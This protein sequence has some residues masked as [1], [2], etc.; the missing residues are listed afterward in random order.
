ML[1][2]NK[3]IETNFPAAN[4]LKLGGAVLAGALVA[5]DIVKGIH[6]AS[7]RRDYTELCSNDLVDADQTVVWL[8]GCSQDGK[9]AYKQLVA[10]TSGVNI[11][12]PRLPERS[13]NGS[14]NGREI[15]KLVLDKLLETGAKKPKIIADSRGALDAILLT[16]M[17]HESGASDQFGGFSEVIFNASPHDGNDIT[18]SR[19]RLL[20]GAIGLQYSSIAEHIKQRIMKGSSHK[21]IGKAPMTK[22]VAEGRSIRQA[23]A[24][25]HIPPVMEKLIY[26]R[27][28]YHDS[29]VYAAQ[30]AEKYRVEAPAGTFQEYIDYSREPGTHIGGR[31]RFDLLLELAGITRPAVQEAQPIESP[32]MLPQAA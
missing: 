13:A 21:S 15:G 6:D 20:N 24:F 29:T 2:Q 22:I 23:P 17:A 9:D 32:F 7:E 30:A 19:N 11:I 31:E 28:Q 3:Y 1:E 26:V 10:K 14:V 8:V 16:Q 4:L 5:T 25:N 12:V 18:P 27:G